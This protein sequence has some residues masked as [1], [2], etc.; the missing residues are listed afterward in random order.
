MTHSRTHPHTY[1]HMVQIITSGDN[2]D[3][4]HVNL[5]KIKGQF[6]TCKN[7]PVPSGDSC[8]KSFE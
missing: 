7:F 3:S 8:Q 2:I 1:T 4:D 5:I 6:H